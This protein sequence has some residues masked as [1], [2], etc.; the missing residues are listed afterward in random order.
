M[1]YAAL[2]AGADGL[3]VEVH[4]RPSDAW[5]DKEQQVTPDSLQKILDNLV[6]RKVTTDD[7]LVLNT[8][9]KLREQ[10]DKIDYKM[11]DLLAQRMGLVEKIGQFK[12]E[13][14]ITILQP[15]RWNEIVI[16]RSGTAKKTALPKELILKIF[17]LIHEE[18][19]RKQT[20]IM[21]RKEER[22][23]I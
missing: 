6:L 2:A 5:S 7:V 17:E 21:N 11:L 18:S 22:M 13:N 9:E 16:T 3:M 4:H 1:A 8:L 20:E 10:I 14:N 15:E 12:K 23:K 19:I